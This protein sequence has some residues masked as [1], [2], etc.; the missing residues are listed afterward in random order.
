MTDS[1]TTTASAA[2]LHET[3]TLLSRLARVLV[4][5]MTTLSLRLVKLATSLVRHVLVPLLSIAQAAK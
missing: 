4:A 1:S 3:T 5:Q 2:P